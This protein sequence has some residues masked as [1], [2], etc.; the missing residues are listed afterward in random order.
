M[1][2]RPDRLA[3]SLATL[4]LLALPMLSG[5][6]QGGSS[7]AARAVAPQ[8]AT[9]RAESTERAQA[10]EPGWLAGG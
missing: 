8:T 7:I 4:L 5:C 6:G 1:S 10:D 9:M 2:I 3:V